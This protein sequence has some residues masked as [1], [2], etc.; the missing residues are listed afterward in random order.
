M[1]PID[2]KIGN[3]VYWK[4]PDGGCCSGSGKVVAV[5]N[6]PP[7]EDSVISLAMRRG[8]TV[9]CY[10]CELY[11]EGHLHNFMFDVAFSIEG[12]WQNW[13]DV[14]PKEL[15]EALQRRVDFLRENPAEAIEAFGFSD[16]YEVPK[17]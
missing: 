2:V 17:E 3:T 6:D 7:E 10:A 5:Q 1:I 9:E 15:V 16:E 4:D 12:Y 14:P 11:P 13:R 8:S